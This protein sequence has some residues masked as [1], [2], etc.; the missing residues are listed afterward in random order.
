MSTDHS[1]NALIVVHALAASFAMVFGAVQIIRRRK[2]D[3]PHRVLGWTWLACMYFTAFSSFWIQQ[4]RPGNFSWIHGLSAFT[5]VTLSLGL[6]NARRGNIRAHAG[7]MIGTYAGL[8]GAFIGVVAV[9]SRLVPQAFQSNWLAMSALTLGI[10]AV[11]L[12]AVAVVTR[13]LGQAG[14]PSTTREPAAI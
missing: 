4:L 5:I 8:W 11:G 14:M 9:P 3:R 6:W 7:N 13:L 1:W 2:G 12:A 10:V